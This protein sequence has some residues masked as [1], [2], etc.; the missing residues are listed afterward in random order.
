VIGSRRSRWFVVA[1]GSCCALAGPVSTAQASNASIVNTFRAGNA[2]LTR[3]ENKSSKALNTYIHHHRA[4]PVIAALRH[5]VRD[6]RALDRT[7]KRESASSAKGRRGKA[8][9][10]LGLTLIANAYSQLANEIKAA[11]S[12]HPVSRARI[13]KTVATDRKGRAKLI[14]GLRLLGVRVVA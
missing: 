14:K 5:E 2:R 9:V 10:T 13:D 7:I 8:D 3:D 4:R 11:H 12:G 6:I 1:I